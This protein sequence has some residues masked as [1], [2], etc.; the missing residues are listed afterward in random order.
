MVFTGDTLE[1]YV[2]QVSGVIKA[3]AVWIGMV[4]IALGVGIV[5]GLV[6][7]F[8]TP[9]SAAPVVGANL[10]LVVPY[11]RYR[12]LQTFAARALDLPA[13]RRHRVD[14]TSPQAVRRSAAAIRARALPRETAP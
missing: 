4:L 6:G 8:P 11:L 2:D 7:D 9:A 1:A 14:I 3:A 10:F 13:S 5:G 12:R